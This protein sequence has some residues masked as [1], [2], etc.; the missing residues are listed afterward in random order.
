LFSP[1][2][3][4]VAVSSDSTSAGAAGQSQSWRPDRSIP[5]FSTAFAAARIAIDAARRRDAEALA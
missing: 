3:A 5:R 1:A 2:C 4:V